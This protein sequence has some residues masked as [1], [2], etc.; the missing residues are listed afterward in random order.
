M[1]LASS[2][3]LSD[4]RLA[5]R[6]VGAASSRFTPFAFR[7]VEDRADDGRLADPR[8]AGYDQ[9]PWRSAPAYGLLLAGGERNAEAGLDPGEGLVGVDRGPGG[10]PTARLRMIA[11]IV[12][13][14][15]RRW[16][17]KTQR[18]SSTVS[19]DHVTFRRLQ[20]REPRSACLR[21]ISSNS[22]GERQQLVLGQPQSPFSTACSRA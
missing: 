20:G 2:P 22:I 13:S 11:A 5:A 17:R 10:L 16:G 6:P 1:V 3:V 12:S 4:S 14:A 18:T 7:I 9:A 8:S 19:R 15:L 21:P